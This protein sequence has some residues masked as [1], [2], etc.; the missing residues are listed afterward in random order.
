MTF[1]NPI[2]NFD[3]SGACSWWNGCMEAASF[4]GGIA[5]GVCWWA[6]KIPNLCGAFGAATV[7]LVGYLWR[8]RHATAIGAAWAFF[9]VLAG[10]YMTISIFGG[11]T[12]AVSRLFAWW[13]WGS[14][15]AS[16]GEAARTIMNIKGDNVKLSARTWF[17]SI[18]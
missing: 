5:F 8:N 13:G 3:L 11:I 7:S 18:F 17:W 1:Q 10:S 12:M 16:W 4:A 14:A 15:A 9:S 2:T 6:V